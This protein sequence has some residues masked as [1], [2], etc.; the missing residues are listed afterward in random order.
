[1]KSVKRSKRYKND[2]KHVEVDKIYPLDEALVILKKFSAAK[3]DQTVDLAVRLGID[4]KKTDQAVR[5]SV[6]LPKGIG[7]SRKVIV[8]AE[9]DDAADAKKLGA[10]EIGTTDLVKKIQ[11]GWLDFDIAIAHPSMMKYVGKLGKVLGPQGKMPS[12]KS[13]TVTEDIKTAVKEFKAGKIEFRTDAGGTVH[14]PVGKL[15]FKTEDL[16]ENILAFMEHIKQ[17]KPSSAK[18]DYIQKV[19]LSATMSPS[20]LC[21]VEV[22]E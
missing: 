16:K 12:P 14:A 21:A 13:G 8:F 11:D 10:D 17:V 15:S 6:A 5:G 4:V 7:K 19:A 22:V 3:F 2:A 18:G 9:G 1:M 20:V